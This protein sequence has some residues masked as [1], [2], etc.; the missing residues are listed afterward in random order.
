[1]R[2]RGRKAQSTYQKYG[3]VPYRYS[4][5]LRHWEA[6][7]KRGDN[8]AAAKASA[9]HQNRFMRGASLAATEGLPSSATGE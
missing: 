5:T 6:A 2:K 8:R 9:D 7:V 4:D 1:M 3:K